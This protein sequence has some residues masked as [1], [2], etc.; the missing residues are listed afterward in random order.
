MQPVLNVEDV[1]RVEQGL[2]REGVS[3]M[4]LMRRAG[5]SAAHEVVQLG[6][7]ANVLVLVGFGNNG[8]DGWVAAEEMLKAGL[9]VRVVSPLAPS[10]L[11]GD[12]APVVARSAIDAGVPVVVGPPRNQLEKLASEADVI[13]DAMLGTGFHGKPTAPFDI[14]IDVVNGS[15]TRVVA[16]DVPSGLSAQ[17][18]MAPGQC[19][20]ADVTCTMIA[21]KPGL[22]AD[23]GRDMCGVIVVAPLAEQTERLV[24]EAD[25]VA[26]RTEA[27]DY[28]DVIRPPSCAQD[29]FSRGSVLVVG[30]SARYVG[31][32]MMAALAAAR[33]G[34]G[35]V[36]LAVPATIVPQV[37]AH[38]VEIPVV[39]VAATKDGTFDAEAAPVLVKLAERSGACV[40]GPG[41][42]VTAG[43]V[44]VCSKLI[45]SKAPLVM[46]ADALN[47]LA[48]L[49]SN[50]LDNF[51]ELIRRPAPLILTPHRR[52]LGRLMGLPDTPPDSLTSALEAA[53]RIVWANGGS[54]FCVVA[55]GNATACV[56]VDMALLPKPGPAALATAGSG[57]ALAGI[58][59][60]HLARM[61]EGDNLPL[62]CALACEVHGY[63]GSIAAQRYGSNG[64]MATDIIDAVGLAADAVEDRAAFPDD[65]EG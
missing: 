18:G 59:G 49:T 5:T 50:R 16:V 64:A 60:A 3:L 39:G 29:K 4:E 56:G 35:Y 34:A 28:V 47:C 17:T 10:D 33:A 62:L 11:K 63:A 38:M 65:L 12:L 44:A 45:G 57:D 43:T 32:P 25:P 1:R 7:V 2:K 52:E 58:M 8:G 20:E 22:I 19:V 51:P 27:A 36:T 48:R 14:W 40:A 37:Q 61:Q 42:R 23:A 9:K 31:A 30:G 13:L 53:R 26:W 41:M 15:G 21:L 54:E 6:D 55:K 24:L 46:D